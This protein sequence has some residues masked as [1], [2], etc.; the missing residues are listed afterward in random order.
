MIMEACVIRFLSQG[1]F[2]FEIFLKFNIVII[3]ETFSLHVAMALGVLSNILLEA[4]LTVVQIV[5]KIN[6]SLL[7]P[8]N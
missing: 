8:Y 7:H 1:I 6:L 3:N 2:I 5:R 4:D